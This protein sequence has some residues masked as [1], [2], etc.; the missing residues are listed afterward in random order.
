MAQNTD[1]AGR[2]AFQGPGRQVQRPRGARAHRVLVELQGGEGRWSK[3]GAAREKAVQPEERG[4]ARPT[5][6]NAWHRG[7]P[8]APWAFA[9]WAL[10]PL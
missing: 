2:R 5:R 8:C 1:T 10:S 3:E 7:N 9:D 6:E 4:G